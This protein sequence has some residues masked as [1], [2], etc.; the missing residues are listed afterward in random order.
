[1][2][3]GNEDYIDITEG[4]VREL[5]QGIQDAGAQKYSVERFYGTFNPQELYSFVQAK[6]NTTTG[7]VYIRANDDSATARD[8]IGTLYNVNV[9][10]EVL[11]AFPP[12]KEQQI[13]NNTRFTSQMMTDVKAALLTQ[14]VTFSDQTKRI[15]YNGSSSLFR[16]D[17][18]DAQIVRFILEGVTVDFNELI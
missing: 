15:R 12:M 11:V 10:I 9:P 14:K 17:T 13:D 1:M 4:R 18:I 16:D 8:T 6:L 3:A 2:P 5:V 7:S